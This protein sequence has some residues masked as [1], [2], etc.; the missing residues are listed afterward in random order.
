MGG[1]RVQGKQVDA[2]RELIA[3]ARALDEAGVFSI[4]LEGVPDLLADLITK[5]VSAPTIGIGAAGCDGQVLVFH[6]VVGLT[7]DA[8]R[9]K[10]VRHYA[11][12]ESVAVEAVRKFFADVQ[13]GEF[14]SDEESYHMSEEASRAL[15]SDG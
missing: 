12:L 1:Y 9:A 7:G 14:P 3:D 2:A 6:D 13:K 10:F 5:E 8:H 4:V 11:D 15:L